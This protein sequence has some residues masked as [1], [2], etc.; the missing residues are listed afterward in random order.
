MAFTTT[1]AIHQS[2]PADPT[3]VL[4]RYPLISALAG[5][6]ALSLLAMVTVDEPLALWAKHE[7]PADVVAFFKAITDL[8]L[9]GWWIGLAV[10]GVVGGQ[11]ALWMPASQQVAAL[12]RLWRWRGLYLL[13]SIV[14]SGI[15]VNVAKPVI[16]RLRPRYLFED[17]RTG[18]VPFNLE[19]A[20]NSF[21]SGHSQTIAAAM[22]AA[23]VVLPRGAPV[24]LVV[25]VLIVASRVM[26]SVHYLSDTIMGATIGAVVALAVARRMDPKRN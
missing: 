23:W 19:T 21:P 3:R 14:A 13:A 1:A 11:L 15:V 25:A 5:A 20:M 10:V 12:G 8:G 18:F 22:M 7:A 26:T 6:L 2:P 9:G 24:F 4:R 17:G 16:G